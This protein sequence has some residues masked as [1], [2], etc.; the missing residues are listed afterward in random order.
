MVTSPPE[1]RR[2]F[3]RVVA[4]FPAKIKDSSESF[5]DKI[6]LHDASAWGVKLSSREKFFLNDSVSVEVSL[7]DGM[8]PINLRGQVIW[9]KERQDKTWDLGIR[10]HQIR[11]LYMSRLYSHATGSGWKQP[12]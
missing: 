5:G 11:L 12:T 10:F 4:R 3:D 7:P 9:T 1:N 8:F 6:T 2:L